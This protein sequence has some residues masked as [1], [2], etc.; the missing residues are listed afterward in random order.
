MAESR[1][2]KLHLMH[3]SLFSART[4]VHEPDVFDGSD[5]RKLQPFLVQCTLNFHNH[6]DAFTSDSDKVTFTLSYLKGTTLDWFEPSLTSSKSPPWL[7]DYSDFVRE[8]K[9]NFG[10]HY[11]EG[12]AEADLENL[13]MRD[14]QRIVK[15]LESPSLC[16]LPPSSQHKLLDRT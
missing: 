5:T 1:E 2:C 7:D 16:P 13:K 14:N 4:K 8:L 10:P 11:P 12:E 15:Y 3:S 9:N 6:P